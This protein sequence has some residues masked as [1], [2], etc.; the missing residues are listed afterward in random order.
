MENLIR[1]SLAGTVEKNETIAGL[2]DEELFQRL[3][4]QRHQPDES[5]MLA[6]QACS[7]V[8]SFNGED[9]SDSN[10]AELVRLGATVGKNPEEMFR[11]VAELHRRDLVQQRGVWRA[12]LPHAIAN[13]LAAVA[14][15]NI[16]PATIQGILINTAPERLF[17]SFSKRLGYLHTSTEASKMVAQMLGEGGLLNNVASLNDLGGAIFKNVAPVA[18]E[19]ALQA[20]ERALI[21]PTKDSIKSCTQYAPLLRSLAYDAELFDRC[22]R[23]LV[24]LCARETPAEDRQIRDVFS[25]LFTLYL[26]G[27]HA[28][29]EQRLAIIEPLLRADDELSRTLGVAAL[30]SALEAWHFSSLHGFEFGARSRDFGFWPRNTAD[31][32]HWFASALKLCRKIGCA[33]LAA[34]S[35]VR[36]ALAE[37]F[38]GLWTKADM[39]EEL[40]EACRAFAEKRFWPDGWVAV[41]TTQHYDSDGFAPEVVAKLSE[42]EQ[43]LRPVGLIQQVRSVVLSRSARLYLDADFEEEN[44]GDVPSG[45]A[46]LELT[47]QTLGT[48]TASDE[49]AF[50]ELLPELVTT[51]GRLWPFGRGLVEGAADFRP[52]WDRLVTQLG[53]TDVRERKIQILCGCLNALRARTPELVETI[54]EEAIHDPTLGPFYPSLQ[55]Y[56]GIAECGV[57]R[58]IRSLALGIAPLEAYRTLMVAIDAISGADL[59]KL[60]APIAAQP[61]G[62]EVAVQLIESRLHSEK[63]LNRGFTPEV[64]AAGRQLLSNLTFTTN[65]HGR[66]YHLGDLVQQCLREK[67]DARIAQEISRKLKAAVSD[68]RAHVFDCDHLLSALLTVQPLAALDGLFADSG[69]EPEIAIHVFNR[70]DFIQQN[71]FDGVP[72]VELLLWCDRQ[73][74]YRYPLMAA[75]ITAFRAAENAGPVHFTHT[76]LRLLEKAPNRI[77]VVKAF[78]RQFHPSSWSGSR[79]AIVEHNSKLL[80]ELETYPDAAVVRFVAAEKARL[81][82]EVEDERR[83]ENAEDRAMDE[84]FE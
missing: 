43:S 42:L 16:P 75:A 2:N 61:H 32:K 5:L 79:A 53:L 76:A 58:L 38:R 1:V 69:E 29:V 41:R 4:H 44:S 70:F 40:S 7:L 65:D 11:Q 60:L 68:Y 37:Q 27:T 17:R 59:E 33:Q 18:P 35:G 74:E 63:N 62:F 23:L 14:L 15:Q 25:S 3:F 47:A 83:R 36:A 77:E 51:D 56:A 12:V 34:A 10:D 48:A 54:L 9:I 71:P 21:M 8:Y 20:L 72:E 84:R 6:A 50:S 26:S 78:I 73:P 66:D 57:D 82:L 31:V 55:A 64:I 39:Y 81:R 67:A 13:R 45:Y 52:I 46:R 24:S 28:P 19:A 30:K 22:A 80:D 49:T